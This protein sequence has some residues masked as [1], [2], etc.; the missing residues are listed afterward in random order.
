MAHKVKNTAML[1]F[2]V[3]A[4]ALSDIS[5]IWKD[6]EGSNYCLKANLRSQEG[7]HFL[8]EYTSSGVRDSAYCAVRDAMNGEITISEAQE[9]IDAL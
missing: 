3:K 5:L 8:R 4:I 9:I 2:G 1:D 7:A 6:S